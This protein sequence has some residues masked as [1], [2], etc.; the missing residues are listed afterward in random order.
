MKYVPW[1]E[2]GGMPN[3]I[4]DG[5]PTKGTVLTLSHWPGAGTPEQLADDL[6]T[7]IVFRF[8]DRPDMAVDAQAVSN[9]HFDEDG[10][11]GTFAMIDPDGAQQRRDMLIDIASAG[12]FGTYRM[13]DAARVALALSAYADE[14]HSPLSGEVFELPYPQQSAALYRELLGK[15]PEMIDH[16]DRFKDLWMEPAARL[17]RDEARIASGA[18]QIDEL[19]EIDLAVVTVPAEDGEDEGD[20]WSGGA[21]PYAIHNATRRKRILVTDGRRHVVRYRYETWVVYTSEPQLPRVDLAPLA[22]Q[23]NEREQNG[24]WSYDGN[25]SITPA[26]HLRAGTESSLGAS[27]FRTAVEAFLRG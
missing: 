7:Q 22:K 11:C 23:L 5:Y 20:E 17:A 13:L 16:I 25:D 18:I 9:N 24:T 3:V 14:D 10:L 4:V 2:L 19:P 21:H 26:L 27:D 6:S 15:L 12:D 8:L 1:D